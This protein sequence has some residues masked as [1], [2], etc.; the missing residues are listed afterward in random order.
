MV[1]LPM[2]KLFTRHSVVIIFNNYLKIGMWNSIIIHSIVYNL[3]IWRQ[4]IL[5]NFV[6]ICIT[7]RKI[8]DIKSKMHCWICRTPWVYPQM[9]VLYLCVL[10][11]AAWLFFV[12]SPFFYILLKHF[13]FSST[14]LVWPKY[15]LHSSKLAAFK[16]KITK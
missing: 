15:C 16:S 8:S 11:S 7:N 3:S 5:S 1:V 10:L 2:R 13:L 14:S 9:L 12:F 6:S 4:S